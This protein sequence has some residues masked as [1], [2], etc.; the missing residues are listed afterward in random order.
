MKN[1]NRQFRFGAMCVLALATT[2]LAAMDVWVL[3]NLDSGPGSFRDAVSQA[4]V[5]PSINW[6]KFQPGIGAVALKAA[7]VFEGPQAL[8][9][10]GQGASLTPASAETFD[11]FAVTGGG[12]LAL[13]QLGVVGGKANGVVVSV[14]ATATEDVRVD[15]W[16]VTLAN[17]AGYG[18]LIDDLLGAPVGIALTAQRCLV[19]G[20]GTAGDGTRGMDGIRVNERGAGNIAASIKECAFTGNGAD[21]LQLDETDAGDVVLEVLHSMMSGNGTYAKDVQDGLDVDESDEG[22]IVASIVDCEFNDNTDEGLDLNEAGPGSL[23]ASYTQV[24][25]NHNGK[26]LAATEADEGSVH[27]MLNQITATG[28]TK[29]EGVKFDEV[30]EGNLELEIQNAYLAENKEE[31]MQVEQTEGGEVFVRIVNSTFVKNGWD[32]SKKGKFG[33]S[34]IPGTPETGTLRLQHVEFADNRAG[35]YTAVGVEVVEVGTPKD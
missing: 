26:G 10:D 19:T 20:N 1:I 2:Q 28:N 17:N 18:L 32:T 27:A 11:L 12:R 9:V 21:G 31:G 3:N 15:L 30:G 29:K 35:P 14:P 25:A 8:G 5:D 4:N 7:V 6:I 23:Y 22:D 13:A 34:V 24:T 16:Q 33:L